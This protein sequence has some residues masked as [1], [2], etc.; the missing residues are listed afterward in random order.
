MEFFYAGIPQLIAML[1]LV[2]LASCKF[3]DFCH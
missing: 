1:I 3:A 2:R